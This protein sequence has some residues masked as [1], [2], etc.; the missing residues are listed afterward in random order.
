MR[1]QVVSR[2]GFLM[3]SSAVA[4]GALL[5]PRGLL[6]AG[7]RSAPRAAAAQVT[8]ATVNPGVYHISDWAKGAKIFDSYVDLPLATTIQKIYL[9]DSEYLTNP[10]PAH[11]TSLASIGCQFIICFKPSKTIDETTKLAKCLQL[12]NQK[13]IVY[14]AVV[15]QE[16]NCSTKFTPSEYQNYWRRYAPVVKN[17]GVPVCNLVCASSTKSAFAKIEPGFPTKPLPDQ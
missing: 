2:R 15:N 17:H 12:L 8:G 16:W 9:K 6:S 13:G 7:P 5:T 4:A 11:I 3:G 14:R 10:L 1:E